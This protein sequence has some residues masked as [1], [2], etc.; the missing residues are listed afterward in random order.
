[1]FATLVIKFVTALWMIIGSA[2]CVERPSSGI[3][4]VNKLS[5]HSSQATLL[6]SEN[7]TLD[8]V[9]EINYK[10]EKPILVANTVLSATK[11]APWY[12][13]I[14]PIFPDELVKFFSLSMMMFWIIFVFTM[15]RDTKDTLIVTN[16]GAEAIAFLKVILGYC[17]KLF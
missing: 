14:F 2:N 9:N 16:C 1:M 11:K 6:P 10:I 8:L 15:T 12:M 4:T 17:L 5:V 7:L 13:T 3:P